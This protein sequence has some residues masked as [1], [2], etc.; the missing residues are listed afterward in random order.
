M[1]G[2]YTRPTRLTAFP[3]TCFRTTACLLVDFLLYL[4]FASREG[5]CLPGLPSAI[6]WIGQEP[7]SLGGSLS[8]G[9]RL[10]EARSG[11][12]SAGWTAGDTKHT[13]ASSMSR[14]ACLL[15]LG[16]RCG[17]SCPAQIL[18][19]PL[20]AGCAHFGQQM[21]EMQSVITPWIIPILPLLLVDQAH[22]CQWIWVFPLSFCWISLFP[23]LWSERA[24]IF[25]FILGI[26][27]SIHVGVSG[28]QIF[29]APSPGYVED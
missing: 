3:Q 8:L 17:G 16:V 14:E 2:G 27:L 20:W 25:V 29:P 1:W 5:K 15:S 10:G 22:Y 6:K 4:C 12:Y 23:V 21:W 28:L 26:I 13:G 11:S 19:L 18:L 24:N 9:G 7:L